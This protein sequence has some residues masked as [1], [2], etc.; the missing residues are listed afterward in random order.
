MK[1]RNPFAEDGYM[2]EMPAKFV[3]YIWA[4]VLVFL[5]SLATL[6]AMKEII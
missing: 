1:V 2:K 3:E 5:V 6:G 4:L